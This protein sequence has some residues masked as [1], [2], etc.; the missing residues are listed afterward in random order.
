M[1]SS[2][3]LQGNHEDSSMTST[4]SFRVPSAN[5]LETLGLLAFM[6]LFSGLLG[7]SRSESNSAAFPSRGLASSSTSSPKS[8]SALS[9]IGVDGGS[10]FVLDGPEARM[11]D[12]ELPGRDSLV[13]RRASG[14]TPESVRG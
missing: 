7:S 2:V 1:T 14:R 6:A 8:L 10:T 5:D 11:I 12:P 9:W 13:P 3:V 4:T